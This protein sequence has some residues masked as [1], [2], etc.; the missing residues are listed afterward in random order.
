MKYY[1]FCHLDTLLPL[2]EVMVAGGPV[3]ESPEVPVA[4]LQD[5]GVVLNGCGE[6][7]CPATGQQE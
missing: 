3:V 4:E 6:A 1:C 5:P 2:L 7:S